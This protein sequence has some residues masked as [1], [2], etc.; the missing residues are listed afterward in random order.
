MTRIAGDVTSDCI[1][2]KCP[3]FERENVI[4]GQNL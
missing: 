1:V 2:A 4:C 3:A